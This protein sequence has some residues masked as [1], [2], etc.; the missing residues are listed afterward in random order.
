ME[1]I[2]AFSRS[3]LARHKAGDG[4]RNGQPGGSRSLTKK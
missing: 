2:L 4:R 1:Q 3:K